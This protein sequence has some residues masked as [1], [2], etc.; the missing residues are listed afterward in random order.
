[1]DPDRSTVFLENL[2]RTS[3]GLVAADAEGRI[4]YASPSAET[5]FGPLAGLD[6][7]NPPPFDDPRSPF[8]NLIGLWEESKEVGGAG[9]PM[10]IRA[11]TSAV[12][13]FLRVESVPLPSGR[14]FI[15][16]DLT[17]H[18]QGYEPVRR[19]I[20]QLA[21]DLRSPLTS[22]S[23]AAELL[24]SGRVG[25]LPSMQERLVKIVDDGAERMAIIIS[26]AADEGCGG[27]AAS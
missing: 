8:A 1:M 20:S 23:G 15:V 2:S 13:V 16:F 22:I 5:L 6:L 9:T 3:V 7:S 14:L 27:G 18:L 25:A 21:H 10:M 17:Q 12:S 24:L 4:T 11:K 19:M 26:K